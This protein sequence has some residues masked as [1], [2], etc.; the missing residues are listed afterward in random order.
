MPE[1]AVTSVNG[2][3]GTGSRSGGLASPKFGGST[4]FS[5][6][7]PP[8]PTVSAVTRATASTR[9]T[10]AAHQRRG[11][12]QEEAFMGARFSAMVPEPLAAY[13]P[14]AKP[15]AAQRRRSV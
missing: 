7:Q 13:H 15:Q 11:D 14:D 9:D 4:G 10:T 3:C 1:V 5:R 12:F 2:S 8:N 6:V